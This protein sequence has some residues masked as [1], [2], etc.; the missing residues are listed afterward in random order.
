[1]RRLFPVF[2]LLVIV[3]SIVFIVRYAAHDPAK[4]AIR[5]EARFNGVVFAEGLNVPSSA[6]KKQRKIISSLL[7]SGQAAREVSP[8]AIEYPFD[9]SVFPPEIVPPT[10][11]W[12]DKSEKADTWLID[13]S[14][15][16]T[17]GHIAVLAFSKP[18][19]FEIDRACISQN[20]KLPEPITAKNWT[21]DPAV[22][23]AIKQHSLEKTAHI[24]IY[25]FRRSAPKKVLSR[26]QVTFKTSKDPVGAPIFYRDVPLMPTDPEGGDLL[27]GSTIKPLPDAAL[28]LIAWRLRDISRPESRIVM[29]NMPSC[30]N[31][32]SFS[33]DGAMLGMDIDGPQGDKGAYAVSPVSKNMV[34]GRDAI[35]SW[36]Y[37]FKQKPKGQKTIGFLSR[38]SPDGKHVLST[39][40]EEIFVVNYLN[41]EFLQVFYPT[42]GVIACYYADTGTIKLLPGVDNTRYVHCDPVWSPDGKY[43]VFA[44]AE[45]RE[46][47]YQDQVRP[48]FANAPTETQ[49][50]YDLCRM[51]FNNGKGGT[52]EPI[53]GASNNGM[54]NTFPKISP[55][56]RFIV[57]VKCKNGQLMRPDSRLW[58]VPVDGGEAREMTCNTPR[59]NSWHSFSPNGR[60][61]VFSSKSRSFYTQMFLT[62]IDENGNDSPPVL[63]PNSTADNRAVNLPE[64]VNIDYDSLEN[65]DV[66]AVSHM[67]ELL[68]SDEFVKKGQFR[69]AIGALE[70][71]LRE[72]TEDK[73]FRAVVF[74][75][76]GGLVLRSGGNPADAISYIN[77]AIE[78]YPDYSPGYY[79]LGMVQERLGNVREAV[80]SYKSAI[81]LDPQNFWAQNRLART[82]VLSDDPS[83]RNIPEA[84]KLAEKACSISNYQE[85]ALL[86]ILGV[87]YSE[88]GRF[89][90]AAV[91]AN[92]ALQIAL[93]AG[94][95]AHAARIQKEIELYKQNKSISELDTPV[96]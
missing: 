30:A 6:D 41:H 60:W 86:E 63:I 28:P 79:S 58:I 4:I 42:R 9:T 17:P 95:S 51:P 32:H 49:I 31:C 39:V 93:K 38:I 5:Q 72:E 67:R 68:R 2:I 15:E 50:Q 33:K 66:P 74:S 29:R 45:A 44:R 16:N 46:S 56:G 35:I 7:E 85:P 96:P 83:L 12:D 52:P 18:M 14:F 70:D 37:Q 8:L 20:N 11:F 90:E 3:I 40:N 94:R 57:F 92:S 81:R 13:I 10:F 80:K 24:A 82:Y 36:N 26:G 87:A 55:D 77:K 88:T 71:A 22:W 75:N 47:Y 76:M 91:S 65:I 73:K 43:I 59:M 48:E 21:P 54:S 19:Q 23:A 34:I 1:M 25:G 78:S 69:E 64:F 61:L 27:R 62:H 84:V 53:E 89:N